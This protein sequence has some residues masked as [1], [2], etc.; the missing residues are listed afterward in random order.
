M[1]Q[2]RDSI[3]LILMPSNACNLR[4]RHCYNS[5][6]RHINKKMS[7]STI[8]KILKIFADKYR[9]I[10]IIWH[11]GEPL[12]MGIDFYEEVL[13]M[14]RTHIGTQFI[15]HIQSNAT[16]ISIA[17]IDFFINNKIEL[18][19]SFDGQFND[20]LREKTGEVIHA[21]NLMK[22]KN[23]KFGA[24]CVV[25]SETIN[26][27]VEI[28][29]FF[30]LINVSY[31]IT[32]MFLSGEAKKHEELY[33]SPSQY[34]THF[35]SFFD[36]WIKDLQCSITVNPALDYVKMFFGERDRLCAHNSCLT[37]W[38]GIDPYGDIYP[39][40][41]SFSQEYC[42]GNILNYDM[43]TDIFMCEKYQRLLLQSIERRNDCMNTC[44]FYSKCLGGCNN[45]A[46]IGGDI[47]KSN[48]NEC[49][50]HK[51]LLKGIFDRL[52]SFDTRFVG[53]LN[54]TIRKYF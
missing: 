46:I 41:R 19:I 7:I 21:I 36:Y 14:Q 11:G 16:L 40:G 1:N 50:I 28:Y 48:Y 37:K 9:Q 15:N 20:I 31:K 4:C 49:I 26:H 34:T 54:P 33:L 25:C 27:L 38:L 30:K 42:F 39:C 3:N 13:A 32:P 8:D 22:Y 23:Y 12:L 53:N 44:E 47:T 35:L 17:W 51:A 18:G 5:E 24:I 6:T 43:V 29:E 52:Q 45:N 2:L 10:R